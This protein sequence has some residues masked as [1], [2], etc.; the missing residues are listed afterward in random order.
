MPT[1][2][3]ES[4]H[5]SWFRGSFPLFFPFA[6]HFKLF[7]KLHLQ[8]NYYKNIILDITK[9]IFY[10][11]LTI[12]LST[13]YGFQVILL[14]LKT[15]H[16]SK[17]FNVYFSYKLR[18]IRLIIKATIYQMKFSNQITNSIFMPYLVSVFK[19]FTV[20]NKVQNINALSKFG[21]KNFFVT[22]FFNQLFNFLFLLLLS[23][24]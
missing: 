10:Q 2:C 22:N 3:S 4:W 5:P 17:Q 12:I 16:M 1:L 8:N 6:P 20:Q 7:K 9:N 19:T 11:K 13:K 23:L 14:F 15:S 18:T 24:C 21:F